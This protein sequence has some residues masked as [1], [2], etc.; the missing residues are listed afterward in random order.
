MSTTDLAP[1]TDHL[2]SAVPDA[3]RSLLAAGK[4][5]GKAALDSGLDMLLVELVRIRS[6]QLNGCAFCLRMHTR[7]AIAHGE[8]ADRLAVL[9]AWRD[10]AYFSLT[11]RAALAVAEEITLVADHQS[12]RRTPA[13]DA[14]IDPSALTPEQLAAVQWL[15]IVINAFNRISIASHYDVAP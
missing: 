13:V 2:D 14:E 9:P 3:Y 11:E 12:G 4:A 6:S 10:S 15:A 8:V 7:D 5:A 1:R